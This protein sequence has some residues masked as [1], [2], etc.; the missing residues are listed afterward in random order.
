M[1]N[2][3]AHPSVWNHWNGRVFLL[4]SGVVPAYSSLFDGSDCDAACVLTPSVDRLCVTRRTH[5]RQW[6]L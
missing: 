1:I 5:P 6:Y 2:D 4:F 3:V